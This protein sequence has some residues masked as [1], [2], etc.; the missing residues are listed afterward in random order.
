MRR[1]DPSPRSSRPV[2]VG[3]LSAL[4]CLAVAALGTGMPAAAHA[5]VPISAAGVAAL[6]LPTE[7]DT[8]SWSVRPAGA[9]GKP[10]AR[11]HYTLQGTPGGTVADQALVTNLSKVPVTFDIYGTDAFNTATGAFDLLSADRKPTDVGSWMVFKNPTISLRAGETAAIPF[12]IVVPATATPGDHAGGVVVSMISLGAG[13]GEKVNVDARVAARVYLR[14]PGNLRPRMNVA[15]VTAAYRPVSNPF[16][17]GKLD[18]SYTVTNL[19]NIRLQSHPTITVTGPFG[20]VLAK[21]T[22]KD[23]PELLPNGSV[24][25]TET[26]DRVF[27][28]GPLTVK[29]SVEPFPDPQQP[30]GQAIPAASAETSL[31]AMPWNLL[32]LIAVVLLILGALWW[33]YRRRLLSRLDAALA[34]VREALPGGLPSTVDATVTPKTQSRGARS[35]QSGGN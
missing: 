9:D 17:T 6:P 32:I 33:R 1:T 2:R 7:D 21:R 8:R 13:G 4:A 29:V 28:A 16:G 10:D 35:G 26:V 30:V 22:L 12:T 31:W 3:W 23:L 25:F 5:A 11:T 18:V 34:S 20:N 24:T 19:G 15:P 14:I 27:P